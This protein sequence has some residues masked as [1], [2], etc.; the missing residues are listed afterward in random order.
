M[1][2]KIAMLLALVTA[3]SLLLNACGGQ[4]GTA[5]NPSENNGGDPDGASSGG[6]RDTIS[7]AIPADPVLDGWFTTMVNDVIVGRQIYD[8]MLR[9]GENGSVLPG[10]IEEWEFT[11][12][13]HIKVKLREGVKFHDGSDFTSK[14]IQFYF[15]N[16]SGATASRNNMFDFANNEIIDD[17]NMVL[18][19]HMPH[20]EALLSLTRCYVPSSAAVEEMGMDAFT[21]NPVGTGPYSL[22]RWDAASEIELVRFDDYWDGPAATEKLLFKVI[23]DAAARVIELETGGIDIAYSVGTSNYKRVEETDGLKLMSGPATLFILLTYSMSDDIL[24][25]QDVRYALNYAIDKQA[26]IDACYEGYY[27]QMDTIYPADLF[28]TKQVGNYPYD[29]EKAKELLAQAGYP[30]GFDITIQVVADA[31]KRVC[32]AIQSMWQNT[33]NVRST[34]IQMTNNDF[35]ADPQNHYMAAV[36]ALSAPNL[37]GVIINYR[38]DAGRTLQANDQ[39]LHDQIVLQDSTL[40]EAKRTEILSEIQDYIFEKGYT[41]ALANGNMAYAMSEKVE[42][43]PFDNYGAPYLMDVTVRE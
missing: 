20:A 11:D 29:P 15:E 16:M 33:L 19:L 9:A 6:Y 42:N 2:R 43:F 13:T 30:D 22:V 1:N 4:E 37:S 3:F 27:T 18:A 35:E 26:I 17:H 39:W 12:D 10:L 23:P 41:M 36:R 38:M 14:D 7:L 25:S 32:E 24:A 40:D 28:G 8:P 34:I 21:T 31:E 5:Q